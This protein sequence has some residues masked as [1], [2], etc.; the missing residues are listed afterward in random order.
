M[1]SDRSPPS[2]AKVHLVTTRWQTQAREQWTM[3]PSGGPSRPEC[4]RAARRPRPRSERHRRECLVDV[5]EAM[6]LDPY[7]LDPQGASGVV[8]HLRVAAPDRVERVEE[9]AHPPDAGHR[10]LEQLQALL[11]L[12]A[13]GQRQAGDVARGMGEIGDQRRH[14]LLGDRGDDDR[15]GRGGGCSCTGAPRSIRVQH[16]GLP[17]QELGRQVPAAARARGSRSELEPDVL[18]VDVAELG[19]R[20]EQVGSRQGRVKVVWRAGGRN[21]TFGSRPGCCAADAERQDRRLASPARP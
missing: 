13:A 2:C 15:D 7:Q 1:P 9:H 8:H 21:A 3:R 14:G 20:C 17:R 4:S 12:L 6:R 19:E 11:T 5:G 16:I 10:F 18:P